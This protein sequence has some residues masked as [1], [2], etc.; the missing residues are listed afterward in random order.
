[1][2]CLTTAWLPRVACQEKVDDSGRI[3]NFVPRTLI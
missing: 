3:S 1:M 2:N